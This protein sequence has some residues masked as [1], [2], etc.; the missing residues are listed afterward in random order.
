[1]HDFHYPDPLGPPNPAQPCAKLV[2]GTLNVWYCAN[3]YPRDMVCQPGERSVAQDS[4]RPDLWRVNLCK[5]LG[6]YSWKL[7][8]YFFRVVCAEFVCTNSFRMVP[9][10]LFVCCIFSSVWQHRMACCPSPLSTTPWSGP[11]RQD[12]RQTG[13]WPR[14]ALDIWAGHR[15]GSRDRQR[16]RVA[17]AC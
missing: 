10:S 11:S 13:S 15:F 3:G 5:N 14:R 7:V 9:L 2:K 17:R 6:D 12:Q 4:M 8:T 1:M 16:R